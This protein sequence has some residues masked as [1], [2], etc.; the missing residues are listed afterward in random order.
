MKLI[1]NITCIGML[2][3][4]F[5]SSVARITGQ[6]S[7]TDNVLNV[8]LCELLK[9]PENYHDKLVRV[10]GIYRNAFELSELYC[11]NCYDEN[12]R[13]WIESTELSDECSKAKEM[14]RFKEAKTLLVVFVGTFQSSKTGYGHLNAYK[15]QIDVSC[16]EK[17]K[18]LSK[19]TPL[20]RSELRCLNIT[21]RCRQ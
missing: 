1:K 12:K 15:F 11:P 7:E 3:L 21:E 19:K 16:V 4:L 2:F 9:H 20:L 18:I 14:K 10:E 17:Y 8:N 13:V 5:N 6:K